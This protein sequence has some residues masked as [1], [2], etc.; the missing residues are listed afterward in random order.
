MNPSMQPAP[1]PRCRPVSAARNPLSLPT[2]SFPPKGHFSPDFWDYRSLWSISE[3][4]SRIHDVS[5]CVWLL[6]FVR[7]IHVLC[8]YQCVSS[9]CSAV[10]H[11]VRMHN[12]FMILLLMDMWVVSHFGLLETVLQ[13]TFL[14]MTW[15]T[16][17]FGLCVCCE[18]NCWAGLSGLC[19]F[20]QV[21]PSH[22]LLS[23]LL[24]L[25]ERFH[26]FTNSCYSLSFLF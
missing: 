10:F 25:G 22:T 24:G 2:T 14:H 23:T 17:E 13:W 15:D 6:L 9:C 16:W 8:V 20:S 1:R 3:L 5:S 4:S 11:Y 7:F 26:V 12:L 19:L 18:F 21:V